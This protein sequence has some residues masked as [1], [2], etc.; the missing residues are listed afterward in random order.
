MTFHSQQ[1]RLPIIGN[2]KRNRQLTAPFQRF[3]TRAMKSE[4]G[5]RSSTNRT[6]GNQNIM[7]RNFVVMYFFLVVFTDFRFGGTANDSQFTT[8]QA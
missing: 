5:A 4:K 7:L 6:A 3:A 8:I 1:T 2:T